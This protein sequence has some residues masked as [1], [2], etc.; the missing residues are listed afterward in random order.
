MA[1]A[2]NAS[3]IFI[4]C[5]AVRDY[6][7]PEKKLVGDM[8]SFKIDTAKSTVYKFDSDK[9][10]YLNQCEKQDGA[11][12]IWQS[13]GSCFVND[14]SFRVVVVSEHILFHEYF[15]G[16]SATGLG[17]SHQT[18]WTALIAKMIHQRS[19]FIKKQS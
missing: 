10:I 2:Q 16:D 8:I 6:S 13:S 4:N 18:G 7:I 1:H 3:E 14:E 12:K 5:D 15:H 9:G 17:A 19:S 11:L